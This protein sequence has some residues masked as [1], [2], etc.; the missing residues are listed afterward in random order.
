MSTDLQ[1]F[2]HF[3]PGEDASWWARRRLASAGRTLAD[4]CVDAEPDAEAL[5]RAAELVEA[6]L[7]RGGQPHGLADAMAQLGNHAGLIEEPQRPKVLDVHHDGVAGVEPFDDLDP[8]LADHAGAN[9]QALDPV[10]G[11]H[12]EHHGAV[13]AL[14]HRLLGHGHH[15]LVEGDAEVCATARLEAPVVVGLVYA[16][17]AAGWLD[18]AAVTELRSVADVTAALGRTTG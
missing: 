8:A 16:A 6:A 5:E 18:A 10:L 17:V 12:P 2:F 13:R 4:R 1:R 7:A 9:H 14:E 3:D 15:A 11:I